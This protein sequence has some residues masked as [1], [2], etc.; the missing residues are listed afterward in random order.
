[1]MANLKSVLT[2]R[3]LFEQASLHSRSRSVQT[4][5]GRKCVYCGTL[6]ADVFVLGWGRCCKPSNDGSSLGPFQSQ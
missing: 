5:L 2:Q 1:M 6:A 4:Y 3:G